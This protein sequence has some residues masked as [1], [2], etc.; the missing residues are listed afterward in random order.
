[1]KYTIYILIISSLFISCSTKEYKQKQ[2]T[3]EQKI[4]EQKAF[5][6]LEKELNK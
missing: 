6:D 2:R 3:Q 5:N 1:M 4:N